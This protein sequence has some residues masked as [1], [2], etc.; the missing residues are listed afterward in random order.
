MICQLDFAHALKCC[1]FFGA[2]IASEAKQSIS[3][4][5]EVWIAWSLSL[6]CANTSRLSQ[7]MTIEKPRFLLKRRLVSLPVSRE[8]DSLHAR[9]RC[10]SVALPFGDRPPGIVGW[11]ERSD[12]HP[13]STFHVKQILNPPPSK[14]SAGLRD[15]NTPPGYPAPPASSHRGG[16]PAP[17]SAAAPPRA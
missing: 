13:T 4:L 17:L 9:L 1:L 7:A 16:P 8:T 2:V 3:Q 10:P 15:A 14:S 12:T 6:P 5:V 11:V